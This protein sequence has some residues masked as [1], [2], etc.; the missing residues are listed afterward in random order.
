MAIIAGRYGGYGVRPPRL[1]SA[2]RMV[3][4]IPE[5]WKNTYARAARAWRAVPWRHN[6]RA[7]G[8]RAVL[9]A[10]DRHLDPASQGR[11][12][13]APWTCPSGFQP[14]KQR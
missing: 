12:C 10:A 13:I 3:D 1:G 2:S 9:A 5:E 7:G 6:R 14:Q 4:P 8:P 11:E